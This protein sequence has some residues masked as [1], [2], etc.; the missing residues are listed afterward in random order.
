MEREGDMAYQAFFFCLCSYVKETF[1]KNDIIERATVY[2]PK[3]I[4]VNVVCAET[5]QAAFKMLAVACFS[6]ALVQGAFCGNEDLL[7]EVFDGVS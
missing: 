2:A 4:E 7:A 1:C 6:H 3:M 5:G